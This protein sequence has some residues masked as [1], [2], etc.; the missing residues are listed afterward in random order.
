MAVLRWARGDSKSKSSVLG[1]S[2]DLRYVY[3]LLQRRFR[4]VIR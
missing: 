4:V 2:V 3:D 1:L